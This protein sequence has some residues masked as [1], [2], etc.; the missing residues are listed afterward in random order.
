[1]SVIQNVETLTG[2]AAST[3]VKS[4]NG[5]AVRDDNSIHDLSASGNTITYTKGDGSTDT[6]TVATPSHNQAS[7]T[8]NA[9]TGYSKASSASAIAATDSLNTAVGKLEKALD[10]KQASGTYLTPTSNVSEAYLTWGGK[11]FSGSYGCIDAAMVDN[12]GAN[13]LAFGKANGIIVEYS[14][15]NGVTWTD[16]QADESSKKR[17]VAQ[18]GANW[19]IGKS[20]NT[21]GNR[22]NGDC[23]LRITIDTN[24]FKIYTVLNKFIIYVTTNGSQ[25]CWCSLDASLENT[26][27]TWVNFAN[28]VPVS[29][30]SGYN[31][32]NTS[33][34]TTYGNSTANQY[35]LIRFTFGCGSHT[36]TSYAGLQIGRLM[37]FGG[38]GWTTPS[39]MA[40]TG[41]LY[42]FDE[43]QNATF[44]AQVTA[45]QFNGNASTAT[46]LGTS[47]VGNS[48]HPIYLNAG[49]PTASVDYSI[50]STNATSRYLLLRPSDADGAGASHHSFSTKMSYV[51]STDTLTVTNLNGKATSATTANTAKALANT[52]AP[53]WGELA[54]KGTD[55]KY[56]YST[57][58]RQ[59]EGSG[60]WQM[61]T[62]DGQL[63]MQVDGKFYQ[64]E[65]NYPVL[66]SSDIGV[67]VASK[68]HTHTKSDITDFPTIPTVTDTYSS[69][70]SNA[71]SGKAVASALSTV[72]VGS[73]TSADSA[74]SVA[75]NNVTGKPT[76][77]TPSSHNQASS[78]INVM[79]GY[80]KPSSTS[81][82]AA[83]DSL[84]AAIGKLEKADDNSIHDLS[85]NGKTITIT[86][87]D[88][89]TDTIVTEDEKVKITPVYP[90]TNTTYFPTFHIDVQTNA[91]NTTLSASDGFKY[92][93]RNGST[94]EDGLSQLILGNSIKS[95]INNNKTGQLVLFGKNDGYT[96][97]ETSTTKSSANAL[98]LPSESGTLCLT[99]HINH[100]GLN[101][102]FPKDWVSTTNTANK[103]LT[104][105]DRNGVLCSYFRA[106]STS[107][108]RRSELGINNPWLNTADSIRVV[109][110][111]SG[112]YGYAP[113][114]PVE[115]ND[116]K[117]VTADW[118]SADFRTRKTGSIANGSYTDVCSC[119]PYNAV[120]IGDTS[121]AGGGK[122]L[123]D[124]FLVSYTRYGTGT[125]AMYHIAIDN[126]Y[127]P[128]MRI[129]RVAGDASTGALKG[130]Y[131]D[132]VE[133]GI[134]IRHYAL[135]ATTTS[136]CSIN[137]VRLSHYTNQTASA[138]I[139]YTN[140]DGSTY[141]SL[142][143]DA[144]WTDAEFYMSAYKTTA[145][146]AVGGVSTP[147]Y[148]DTD[149]T[150]KACTSLPT[151]THVSMG[152]GYGTCTTAA[153][154]VAKVGTLANYVLTTGGIVS[155]K[156]TYDV[157]A[158]ATLNINSK[159]AKNMRH[160][161]ANIT[162]GVINAGDTATFIYDGSYYELISV[163][164][165]KIMELTQSEYD[166]I[167]PKDA[168]T[169]YF[170][171]Q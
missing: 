144:V 137:V 108:L 24:E 136:V 165:P 15:D 85:V 158:A 93:D 97:I 17:L 26:P 61:G 5:R 62:K 80:S 163:D 78:T 100:D 86:K 111:S 3:Y 94:T 45:T 170:I 166:A 134:A 125:Y 147:V 71:M 44:P 10:G 18:G 66:D 19:V 38:V 6:V 42:S 88:G 95:G 142:P 133:N 143:A 89:A 107:A 113:S 79:T 129:T 104:I 50:P 87:G 119:R 22:A 82:I 139:K 31:V 43:N 96:Q 112:T 103:D 91:N 116:N 30:W 83:T 8:I 121:Y 11:N 55:G 46:K 25:N 162:A 54:K 145:A 47:N 131:Y 52:V 167:N 74:N 157:P 39:T 161:G 32:I 114:T 152:Q 1:M 140:G 171:K 58:F 16:Y 132:T 151:P 27:T 73:A 164:K 135:Q 148:V 53:S 101:L 84:N 23:Q 20:T 126:R 90:T 7:N 120:T 150:I 35:G 67:T 76:S 57:F 124:T 69:T 2:S 40:S 99:N 48:A 156:F 9:M 51:A 81:A 159:G 36:S 123:D 64:N 34:I 65:G 13:R 98:V 92:K 106:S 21:D 72:K 138:S 102:T 59:D 149:G 75:W 14:R 4:I 146:N 63:S 29:G 56:L 155:I 117:I 169:Y 130:G 110:D 141:A 68:S 115:A 49:V 118:F 105:T 77:F 128:Q 127:T 33:N 122:Y 37:G 28:K 160:R 12:L 154:T 153:A 109:A 168:N 41:H 60:S 70:S